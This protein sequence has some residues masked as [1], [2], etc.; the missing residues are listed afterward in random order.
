MS[1]RLS[2][3]DA[4]DMDYETAVVVTVN[5]IE[6]GTTPGITSKSFVLPLLAAMISS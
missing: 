4:Y 3:I 5:D 2:N 6:L 1:T